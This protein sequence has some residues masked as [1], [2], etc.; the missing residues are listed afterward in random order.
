[1]ANDDGIQFMAV[2]CVFSLTQSP[3][4]LP[5]IVESGA[6]DLALDALGHPRCSGRGGG[7]Y[8]L[9][10]LAVVAQVAKEPRFCRRLASPG[11]IDLLVRLARYGT[12]EDEPLSEESGED[13]TV[14]PK[15]EEGDGGAGER[16]RERTYK[17]RLTSPSRRRSG[18][19]VK[20]ASSHLASLRYCVVSIAESLGRSLSDRDGGGEA[21]R[22]SR[23]NIT[24]IVVREKN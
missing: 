21:E 23:A 3:E 5:D 13:D 8:L 17:K 24:Y 15:E 20:V 7:E 22:L 14:S 12:E 6:A 10:Q 1:M 2:A 18:S 4:L 11:T 9:A 16:R 19:A